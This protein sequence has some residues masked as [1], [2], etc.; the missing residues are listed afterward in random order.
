M[1]V[2]KI[3]YIVVHTHTIPAHRT[4]MGRVSLHPSYLLG[5]YDRRSAAHTYPRHETLVALRLLYG[6]QYVASLVEINL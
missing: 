3:V 6:Q 5:P 2:Y 1:I 4:T